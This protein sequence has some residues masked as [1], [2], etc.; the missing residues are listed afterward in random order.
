MRVNKLTAASL[1]TIIVV[2]IG[3]LWWAGRAPGRPANLSPKALYIERGV[4]PV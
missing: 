1:G 2:V 3:V 4:V